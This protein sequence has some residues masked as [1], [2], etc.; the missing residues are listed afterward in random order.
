MEVKALFQPLP[1]PVNISR[2][3]RVIVTMAAAHCFPIGDVSLARTDML[4]IKLIVGL[5]GISPGYR[6]FVSQN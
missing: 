3:P 6:N 4:K 2:D 5:T 1:K